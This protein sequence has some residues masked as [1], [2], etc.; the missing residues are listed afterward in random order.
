MGNTNV[1]ARAT[2]NASMLSKKEMDDGV[3]VLEHKILKQRPE[4]VCL[5]GK[6]IWEAVF[7]VIKGTPIKQEEFRYGWQD[8]ILRIG[9]RSGSDWP[10]ARVFVATTTSGL[11]TNFTFDER[12]KI[13][14]KLGNWVKERREERG[15][16]P[17]VS[18]SA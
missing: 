16:I 1:V 14:T 8:E 2:L 6:G 9:E 15:L 18:N 13:W 5:V 4:A 7:R 10:G 3:L 11:S 12:L 17:A